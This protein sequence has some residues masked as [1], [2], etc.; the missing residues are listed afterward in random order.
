MT[1]PSTQPPARVAL[2]PSQIVARYSLPRDRIYKAINSH[3]LPAYDVGSPARPA[4]LVYIDDVESW[5]ASLRV[6]TK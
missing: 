5:L 3:E 2:R 4:F 6:G 1:Y